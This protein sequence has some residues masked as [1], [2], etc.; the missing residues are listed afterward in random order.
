MKPLVF[1]LGAPLT[2]LLAGCVLSGKE[3]KQKAAAVPPPPKPA[4]ATPAPSPAPQAPLS[5]PQTVADLPAPQPINPDALPTIKL[6][7]E[8]A[9]T[10]PAPRPRPPRAGQVAGPPKAEPPP[11]TA[12]TPP[13]PA[14]AEPQQ[15][16]APIQEILPP[17]ESKRLQD[18]AQ[19]KKRDIKKVLDQIDVRKLNSAQ[20]DLVQRIKTLVQQ[21]DDAEGKNEM[22]QAEALAG[23]AQVLM[24]ELQGGR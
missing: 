20:R 23:Q 4:S 21:S 5:I 18:S 6:P 7:E 3:Q 22:R 8:G 17:A 1:I 24:R 12:Q 19:G 14:P 15:E 11:V 9:E 16:R 10:P 13:S 2:L